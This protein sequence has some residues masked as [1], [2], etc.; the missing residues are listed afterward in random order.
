MTGEEGK[1]RE[2]DEAQDGQIG[3]GIWWDQQCSPF[4]DSYIAAT[5]QNSGNQNSLH[6]IQCCPLCHHCHAN[7]D[8]SVCYVEPLHSTAWK[9]HRIES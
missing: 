5:G 4:Q 9:Y 3:L 8:K 6:R 2:R 7:L 1:E